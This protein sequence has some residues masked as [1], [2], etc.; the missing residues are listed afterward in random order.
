MR[1]MNPSKPTLLLALSF[2]LLAACASQP[3]DSTLGARTYN[4]HCASCHG[5]LGE[6]DG[7]V[8]GVM[9]VSVPNLRTLERRNGGEFPT[10]AVAG[11]IDGRNLPVAHGYRVMPVWGDVFDTTSRLVEDAPEARARIAAVVDY[12][13]EL[14]YE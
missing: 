1:G 8:A 14:Q 9:Q 13:R 7:P 5:M 6:G 2:S 11:F 3:A 10:D 4:T 12:L